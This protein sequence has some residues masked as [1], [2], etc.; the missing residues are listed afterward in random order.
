MY[1]ARTL[2]LDV[3]SPA[4]SFIHLL[5]ARSSLLKA[6]LLFDVRWSFIHS[7]H[8]LDADTI[9]DLSFFRPFQIVHDALHYILFPPSC[10]C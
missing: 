5:A 9:L 8:H 4:S 10:N 7:Y 2:R 3:G 6:C 1:K